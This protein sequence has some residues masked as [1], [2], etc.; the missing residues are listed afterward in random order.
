MKASEQYFI[1]VLFVFQVLRKSN[2]YNHCYKAERI[3]LNETRTVSF[4]KWSTL[5]T[6]IFFPKI[7]YK[8]DGKTNSQNSICILADI[9][10]I[11]ATI[12]MVITICNE[13]Y[14]FVAQLVETPNQD[15]DIFSILFC[16]C[17]NFSPTLRTISLLD[18]GYC[19]NNSNNFLGKTDKFSLPS[20]SSVNQFDK[21]FKFTHSK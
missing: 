18:N 10:T 14:G 2:S 11:I 3:L 13:I 5:S 21:E 4:S 17:Q 20:G 7:L 9:T 1:V 15:L 16:N 6:S 8:I 19:N 12:I